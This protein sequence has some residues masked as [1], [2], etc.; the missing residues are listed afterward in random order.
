MAV[1]VK[2]SD[3]AAE[4]RRTFPKHNKAVYSMAKRTY[5]TG[6]ML[7]P[8]AERIKAE[9]LKQVQPRKPENRKF[10]FRIYGR[11][12]DELAARVQTKMAEQKLTMQDLL[13]N[14][15]TEW[16]FKEEANHG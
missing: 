5:E 2:D 14:L 4:I 6:V 8:E 16:V 9:F 12:P 15:L 11:I 1:M 7:C 13:L 10:R 3:I